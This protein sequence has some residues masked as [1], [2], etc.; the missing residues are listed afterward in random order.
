MK[1]T[2]F[3]SALLLAT[4]AMTVACDSI[5]EEQRGLPTDGDADGDGDGDADGDADGD[6]ENQGTMI[7][8]E[9]EPIIFKAIVRDF[10]KGTGS[11]CN[12]DFNRTE[13]GERDEKGIV[14]ETL[15][16]DGK[17]VFNKPN[18]ITTTSEANF[19]QWYNTVQ[20]INME[21]PYQLELTQDPGNPQNWSFDTDRF[22]PLKTTDGFGD[23]GDRDLGGQIQNFR[24]TTEFRMTFKYRKGQIFTFRGD[25]DVF[26]FIN[27][28]LVIDIGGIHSPIEASVN[29]DTLGLTEGNDYKMDIFHA[30]RNPTGSNFRITTNIECIKPVEID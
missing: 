21:F 25:D 23:Q 7:C 11:D 2:F 24:F 6:T 9:G 8:K 30:E 20:G 16:A 1:P 12:P 18:G 28:K 4:L 13:S 14:K 27:K 22:F 19:K 3:L 29:L 17:P 26:V 10:K 5:D 15:G